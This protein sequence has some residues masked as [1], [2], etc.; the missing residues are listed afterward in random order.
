MIILTDCLTETVD[1]GCLKVANS[2]TKRIK[3][4]NPNATV[5]SYGRKSKDSDIFINLNK[6]FWNKKLFDEINRHD[7]NILYIPFSSNTP[8]SIFRTFMLSIMS[9]KKVAVLFVLRHPMR[10]LAKL[11][12]KGSKA[13]IVTLSRKSFEFYSA[14]VGK[15]VLYLK[16]GV[17]VHQFAPVDDNQK[18]ELKQKYGLDKNKPVILHVGHLNEGRNIEALGGIT[19]D[20]QVLLII[21]TICNQNEEI[22][23]RLESKNN[24]RIIDEYCPEIHEIY[25]LSDVYVFPVMKEENCI[26]VP[27]SVLEA[28]SCNIPILATPY[29]ELREFIGENGIIFKDAILAENIDEELN[30]VLKIKE[31]DNRKMVIPYDWEDSTKI[32]NEWIQTL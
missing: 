21:S 23:T 2:L 8:A 7:G 16:T 24:I 27:L 11:F 6:L 28:A 14:I 31:F 17:D 13:H 20:K 32:L 18:I 29:G 9:K 5:I 3:K 4:N 19:E 1:E 30:K 12:L 22:R 15:R 25:Q 26:D 10:K